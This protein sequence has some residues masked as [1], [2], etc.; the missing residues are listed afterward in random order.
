MNHLDLTCQT[1]NQVTI[2]YMFFSSTHG[3]LSTIGHILGH[4]TSFKTKGVKLYQV[5]SLN[6]MELVYNSATERNWGWVLRN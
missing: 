6:A 4:K 5:C 1:L 3:I 2:E